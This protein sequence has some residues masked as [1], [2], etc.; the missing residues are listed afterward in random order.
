MDLA[1]VEHDN[2][3]SKIYEIRG[4][5]VMLDSDLAQLYG[6]TT[7]NLNKA[8]KRN[9]EKFPP[10]FCFQ[11]DEN[12]ANEYL[13]FQAGTSKRGG[14][15]YLPYAYTEHG[16]LMLTVLFMDGMHPTHN[17]QTGKAWIKC[18]SK[19]EVPTN[20]GRKRCNLNGFYNP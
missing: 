13:R 9:I 16:V 5:K 8:M 7:G 18:G 6:V 11:L 20:S 10:D 4:L 19:K 12:E 15:R 2:I 17:L 14:R 3:A 1:I